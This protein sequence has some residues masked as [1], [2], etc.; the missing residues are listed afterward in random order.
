MSLDGLSRKKRFK[1]RPARVLHVGPL[2]LDESSAGLPGLP[3]TLRNLCATSAHAAMVRAFDTAI[4]HN[5]D[6]VLLSAGFPDPEQ[7]GFRGLALAYDQCRRLIE[8]RIPVIAGRNPA[9]AESRFGYLRPPVN[10]HFIEDS[11]RNAITIGDIA[12]R[13]RLDIGLPTMVS[14]ARLRVVMTD[15][16]EAPGCVALQTDVDYVALGQQANPTHWESPSSAVI[17][18]AGVLQGRCVEEA[19]SHGAMLV[20]LAR[21]SVAEIEHMPCDV[22]R[23]HESVIDVPTGTEWE[24][25]H[26][27]LWS[28][29]E[30]LHADTSVAAHIV[31]WTVRGDSATWPAWNSRLAHAD[32]L[33]AVR[34]SFATPASGAAVWPA[35]LSTEIGSLRSTTATG[36]A[37][38]DEGLSSVDRF[39]ATLETQQPRYGERAMQS[40][41][42]LLA[43]W[44]FTSS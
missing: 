20:T 27:I 13:G 29:V 31:H 1:D 40:V 10:V 32:L 8:H 3:E 39:A 44:K 6:A 41:V 12:R 36:K 37:H 14:N 17:C 25:L 9:S 23:H 30:K 26:H 43:Q 35:S 21:K 16:P 5:V 15:Q 4:T 11:A 18:D 42:P 19:G 7:I 28:E 33:A 22:V 38:L 24:R 2:R 34:N